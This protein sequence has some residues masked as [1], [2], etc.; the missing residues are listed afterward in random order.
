M[1]PNNRP[2]GNEH[3]D[4]HLGSASAPFTF[5][6]AGSPAVLRQGAEAS[7]Q[8]HAKGARFLVIN[9][10]HMKPFA[11]RHVLHGPAG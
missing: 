6:V 2:S 11:P 7:E 8:P 4:W 1:V 3:S 10:K 5:Q 9:L